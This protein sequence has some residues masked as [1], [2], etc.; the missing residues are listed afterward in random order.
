MKS[1]PITKAYA[2]Y[3]AALTLAGIYAR[4]LKDAKTTIKVTNPPRATS[5]EKGDLPS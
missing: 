4:R 5:G 2:Q 1:T 3:L